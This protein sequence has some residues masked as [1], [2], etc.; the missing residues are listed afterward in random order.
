M[1]WV[2]LRVVFVVLPAW[3][4]YAVSMFLI[5]PKRHRA[6]WD[7]RWACGFELHDFRTT[8]EVWTYQ[9]ARCGERRFACPH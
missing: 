8:S 7:K 3:V 9:C 4:V 5:P 6:I 2:L 1:I